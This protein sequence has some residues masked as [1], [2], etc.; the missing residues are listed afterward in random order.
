MTR[1][2]LDVDTGIDDALALAYLATFDTVDVL[3]VIGT[4]GNVSVDTAVR[5]TSYVLE[6]LGLRHIPVIRGSSHP[7]WARCF[8]PDAGCAKFHGT[9]G[10]GGFGPACD[11]SSSDTAFSDIFSDNSGSD[12]VF[13]RDY[14][15]LISVGGYALD[16]VHANPAVDSFELSLTTDS[17]SFIHVDDSS[18]DSVSEGV[19]FII[20]QVRAYGFDVTVVATGPLT[21]ID[22]AIAAAPDIAGKL[23]L[24]M[25]GGTLTQEGNCW[26]LTAET[27]IIQDPEAA[28]RVFHSGADITMVG[29]DVTHQCLMGSDTTRA[30][31]EAA[32]ADTLGD[33]AGNSNAA[34]ARTSSSD[35]G[36]SAS[37]V[38]VFLAGMAD[39]SI[40]ANYK[41]D[42]RL[43]SQGMPLHDPLAAAVAVDPSLVNCIDLPMKVELET[44]DFH[45]TRGRTIGD[46]AGLIDSNAP[47]IHVALQVDSHRFVSD[48]TTRIK[49]L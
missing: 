31:R 6:R 22:A 15:S 39:F 21:D 13:S 46:P 20:D 24:V 5:N 8:I 43:F 37:D 45:G 27:N 38:R 9:D 36:P 1:L 7:S 42:A 26:D 12:T 14:R 16:D 49:S 4:Y 30:W 17:A 33:P 10:L 35:S 40:A 44:G 34:S 2:I 23:K 25:M 41:A 19:Q 48:F 32:N 47:R 18:A 29:L 3:G 11:S 28:D